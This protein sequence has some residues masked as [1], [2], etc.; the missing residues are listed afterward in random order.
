MNNEQE[1]TN[2]DF[3]SEEKREQGAGLPAA[4]SDSEF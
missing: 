4:S 3:R 2:V 1:L